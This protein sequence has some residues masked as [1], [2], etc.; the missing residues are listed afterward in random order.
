MIRTTPAFSIT[1]YDELKKL[2]AASWFAIS[3][4]SGCTPFRFAPSSSA[5]PLITLCR[6]PVIMRS[7]LIRKR[8]TLQRCF[9]LATYWFI[10]AIFADTLDSL[11]PSLSILAISFRSATCSE[12]FSPITLTFLSV[13]DGCLPSATSCF[14]SPRSRFGP[15]HT[16]WSAAYARM[17][18]SGNIT[19]VMIASSS[20]TM[21]G[22]HTMYTTYIQIYATTEK[23]AV[24]RKTGSSEMQRFSPA[25]TDT[26]HTAVMTS[27]LYEAEPTIVDAPSSPGSCS[28]HVPR[29]VTV[30]PTARRI[31]GADEPSAIS[32][33]FATVAF[34]N[35]TF[36]STFS[37]V[38][39]STFFIVVSLLVITS[40][41]DMN[42]SEMCATPRK[43]YARKRNQTTARKVWLRSV[44]PGRSSHESSHS[45]KSS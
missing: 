7:A 3:A 1:L 25:G 42:T 40:I 36:T 11:P 20:D 16:R 38:F 34:Q 33:K 26:M 17:T 32:V 8:P 21:S 23:K 2:T 5:P 4:G 15:R 13:K 24:V 22:V 44:K 39:G 43:R 30:S 10:L 27:R 35:S 6:P 28:S 12:P 37:P 45:L 19:A 41:E 31:S 14:V 18:S 29:D 9:T